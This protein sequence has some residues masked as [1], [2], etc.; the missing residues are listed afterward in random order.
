MSQPTENACLQNWLM[1]EADLRPLVS[2]LLGV[3]WGTVGDAG[4]V[5][6]RSQARHL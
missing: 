5:H 6:S 4:S 3:Q 1:V 2:L